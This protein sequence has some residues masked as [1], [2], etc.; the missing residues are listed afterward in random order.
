MQMNRR[1]AIKTISLGT[2]ALMASPLT[3]LAVEPSVSTSSGLRYPF[4][5]PDLPYAYDALAE[6]ID[7]ETMTIHHTKHHAGYVKNLNAALEAASPEYQNM[8]LEELL[9]P[10]TSGFPESLVTAVI[11]HGGGHANHTLFWKILSPEAGGKPEGR[12]AD[13]IG[14]QFG[15]FEGC[16]E[17]LQKTAMSVFGSGWAWLSI[18]SEGLVI[19]K[20]PNQNSPLLVGRKPLLGI[21]VWEHAYY[22]HYQNRRLDYVNAVLDHINW[23]AVADQLP[24]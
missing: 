15:S 17:Q 14:Q 19:E 21:D 4:T 16:V 9:T 18:G 24:A 8:T 6:F 7:P 12:L 22:L 23:Q 20:T 11:N 2:A 5:L 13:M 3:N 1:D 10:Q